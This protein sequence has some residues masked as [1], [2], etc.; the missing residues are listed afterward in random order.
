MM[1]VKNKKEGG[2]EVKEEPSGLL[3]KFDISRL[4]SVRLCKPRRTEYVQPTHAVHVHERLH[5]VGARLT[6]IRDAPFRLPIYA[7]L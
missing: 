4:T 7:L 1:V 6:G 3:S 2:G 5:V